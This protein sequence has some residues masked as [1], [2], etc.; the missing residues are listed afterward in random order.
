MKKREQRELEME[1]YKDSRYK[2]KIVSS[3]RKYNRKKDKAK[4]RK[5][6]E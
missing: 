4:W 1:L 2:L 6:Y 5:E 3:K